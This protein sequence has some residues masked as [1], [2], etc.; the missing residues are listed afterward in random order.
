MWKARENNINKNSSIKNNA[1]K[2]IKKISTIIAIE[3]AKKSSL[4]PL[5]K[6]S[7][8]ILIWQISKR[9]WKV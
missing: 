8:R 4:K 3:S 5:I 7:L 9:A 1:L 2:E 6:T